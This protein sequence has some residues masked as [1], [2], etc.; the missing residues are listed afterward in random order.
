MHHIVKLIIQNY[1]KKKK[2]SKQ[3]SDF[4]FLNRIT[5]EALC[6]TLEGGGLMAWNEFYCKINDTKITQ[7][8]V[9][10]CKD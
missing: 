3:Y 10:L 2:K 5:S 8:V 7:K 6:D 4:C 1:R 9:L